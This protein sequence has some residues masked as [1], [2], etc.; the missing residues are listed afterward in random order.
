MNHYLYIWQGDYNYKN[1]DY[2]ILRDFILDH[3]NVDENLQSLAALMLML[4][5]TSYEKFISNIA[6]KIIYMIE[7]HLNLIDEDFII[8]HI[9]GAI[10]SMYNYKGE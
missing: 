1:D 3:Y 2:I 10:E 9:K 8:G 5:N 7:N 6:D 4:P